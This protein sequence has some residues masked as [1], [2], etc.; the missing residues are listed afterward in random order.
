MM[1][2]EKGENGSIWVAEGSQPAYE[3]GFPD[4]KVLKK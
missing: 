1:V 4:R 2:L 3:V